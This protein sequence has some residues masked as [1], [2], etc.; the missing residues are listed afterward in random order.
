MPHPIHERAVEWLRAMGYRAIFSLSI[1]DRIGFTS[2]D[3]RADENKRKMKIPDLA[4]WSEPDDRCHVIIE[5]A[6]GQRYKD[7]MEVIEFWRE[8]YPEFKRIILINVTEAP[9]YR[10]PQE[11]TLDQLKELSKALQKKQFHCESYRGPLYC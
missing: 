11:L 8:E 5:I 6:F 10:R 4:I 3:Q 2:E 1:F 9:E 7:A